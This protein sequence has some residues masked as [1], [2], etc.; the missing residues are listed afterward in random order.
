VEQGFAETEEVDK[1]IE[2]GLGR[3]LPVTGPICTADLAGL[4]VVYSVEKY[5]FKDLCNSL[6]PSKLIK[7]KVENGELGSKS[8]KGFYNWGPD[9]L[10]KKQKERAELLS[11]FLERDSE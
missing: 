10:E 9:I 2:F 11:Y 1:A 8:G 5:L 6:E 4:D 7:M 3:R